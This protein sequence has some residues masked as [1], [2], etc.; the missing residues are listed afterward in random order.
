MADNALQIWLHGVHIADLTETTRGGLR[1]RYTE[2]ALGRWPRNAPII[3]CSL[4]L[5]ERAVS[6]E[7]F[8]R[9]LLPEGAALEALAA[10]ADVRASDIF[11]LLAR[12][13]RDIAG[14]LVFSDGPVDAGRYAVE[15]YSAD[16][17]AQEVAELEQHPLGVHDDSELSIAGLQNKMLLVA[18][19]DGGWGRPV[20]G[21]PSTHILKVD[22]AAWPGLIEAEAGCLALAETIG[23]TSID[24][25]VVRIGAQACL[26]VARFDRQI[27]AGGIERLHQEDACQALGREPKYQSRNRGGPSLREIA[28]LLD[29][30][31]ADPTEQLRKLLSVATFNLA[32]GNGDCHGKNIALLHDPV[33]TVRL[34]PIYDTVPTIMWS[35]L[36]TESAM[37]LDGRYSL[38]DCDRSDLIAEARTWPLPEATA[39]EIVNNTLEQLSDALRS[40]T[41]PLRA[42]L[43]RTIS[44]RVKNLLAGATAGPP[45]APFA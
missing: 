7:P 42:K 12:Y 37:A 27:T 30:Y 33:D 10:R 32:I 14:A 34:A 24:Q 13:G 19:D 25:T 40:N 18:L 45:A 35:R 22:S 6:A 36:R 23:L 39:R 4:P 15:P 26:I 11:G 29:R 1:C 2:E 31:A 41:L 17:L 3:S 38:A 20:H 8:L 44:K 9:G 21:Q 43:A 28:G 16:G 5:G